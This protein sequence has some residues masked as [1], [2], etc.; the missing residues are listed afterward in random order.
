LYRNDTTLKP[1]ILL[2]KNGLGNKSL[3][4]S[5]IENDFDVVEVHPQKTAFEMLQTVIPDLVV[6][7]GDPKD[8][9]AYETC[10]QIKF[11]DK[12]YFIPLIFTGPVFSPEDNVK[13]I[14]SGADGYLLESV[15]T[16][17]TMAYLRALLKK[18]QHYKSLAEKYDQLVKEGS[19]EKEIPRESTNQEDEELFRITFEQFAVGIARVD[20]NG[21]F[22]KVNNRFCEIVGYT[23]EELLSKNFQDL[24]Y[25]DSRDIED[26][27][28]AS[29]L[30]GEI[31]SFEVEKR[32]IHKRGHLIWV[33]L[34]SSV[35]RDESGSIKYAIAVVAEISK[36]K[37]AESLRYESEALFRS[38]YESSGI[39]I[40]RMSVNDKIIEQANTAFCRMLGYTE[41]ELIGKTL[42]E[43]S[44]AED[45]P[46]NIAQQK[47]LASGEINS[48]QMEKR[49]LHKDGHHVCCLLHANLIYDEQG[50]PL[51]FIGNVLDITEAKKSQKLLKE[52]EKK[53]RTYVDNS[54]HPIFVA[55]ASGRYL[56]LNQAACALTGY[57]R[58][59][60]LS[61]NIADLCAPEYLEGAGM[62]FGTVLNQGKASGE[63]QF[64]KKDGTRFYMQV[65]AVKLNENTFLGLCVETTECKMAEKLLIEAKLLAEDASKSKSEFVANIS[66]ELRTPL[67]IVI[68]YSDLLL[69]GT[70]GEL[71]EKQTKFASNIKDAGSNLLEI[72][73]SLIYIAEIEGGNSEFEITKFNLTPLIAGMEKITSLIASKRGISIEFEIETGIDTITA[74]ESKFKVILHQLIGNS[75]KFTPNN[76]SVKVSINQDDNNLCVHVRDNGIGIPEEKQA[77]LF[78]PFVQLEWSHA[79]KY[80]GVGIGLAL[81]KG[82]VEMHGGNISLESK[83]GEGSTF[84][85]TIPQN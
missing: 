27:L 48:I 20:V 24:T 85:F 78:D 15:D 49:Y 16:I 68:G 5:I 8:P 32:Y 63:F 46:E 50:S 83:V 36:Q 1:K 31:D 81:A 55:D 74:D 79:R 44:Y 75:I 70:G 43:I 21:N 61:M 45:L 25:P 19:A 59:E 52:S 41:E 72:V 77:Q 18:N 69:S 29:V 33:K 54:P 64:L 4:Q 34:Y 58:E 57:S 11:S 76:G 80:G 10:Q 84:T 42:R 6:L 56:D 60:L 40:V 2:A 35:V 73:N 66:H 3:F 51:Y 82:L 47:K 22:Q 30:A 62:H 71:N 53:Y 39:G 12:Y 13:L 67:N 26:K 14:E 38:M 17:G 37:K 7:E 23:K 28:I 65:E 9:E